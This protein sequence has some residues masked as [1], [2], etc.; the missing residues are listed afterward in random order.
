MVQTWWPRHSAHKHVIMKSQDQISHFLSQQKEYPLV[1]ST[2]DVNLQT[3]FQS[4]NRNNLMH[5]KKECAPN[6]L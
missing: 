6:A 4:Y 5:P 3:T 1:V 2:C